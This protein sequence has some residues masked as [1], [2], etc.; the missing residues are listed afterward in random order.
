MFSAGSALDVTSNSKS[1]WTSGGPIVSKLKFLS[2]LYNARCC[3]FLVYIIQCPMLRVSC[4][5]CTMPDAAGFWSI[6]YNARCCGFL[7]C[8]VQCPMLR[9]SCL[10]CTMPD[11]A[12]FLSILYSARC[13]GFLV[14]IVQCPMLRVSCLYCTMTD[15]AGMIIGWFKFVLKTTGCR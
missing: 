7:V 11:A 14:Y 13:C 10:Y 3:G 5:Y 8:I 1:Y 15:A 2:I 12:G 9:V 6:L 4:L